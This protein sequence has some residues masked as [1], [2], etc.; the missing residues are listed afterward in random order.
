MTEVM[1]GNQWNMQYFSTAQSAVC[2]AIHNLLLQ[3]YRDEI[4][5]FPTLPKAWMDKQLEFNNLLASGLNVSATLVDPIQHVKGVV[6]NIAPISLTRRICFG[7]Q[8]MTMTLQPGEVQ[9][10]DL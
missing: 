3:V 2:T 9:R 10:F 5:L 7:R 6:R 4:H 8:S 1:A